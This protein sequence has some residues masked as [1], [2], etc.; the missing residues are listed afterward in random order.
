MAC[1]ESHKIRMH[2]GGLS[3]CQ[4]RFICQD[5]GEM[6][7]ALK[8]RDNAA[9]EHR[10]GKY[11]CRNCGKLL[12]DPGHFCF[13]KPHTDLPKIKRSF[14]YADFE[15]DISQ[16]EHRVI[17]A[18]A[19]DEKGKRKTFC[20]NTAGDDFSRWLFSKGHA[21]HIVIFHNLMAYDSAFTVQYLQKNH[22]YLEVIV[23]G[24][25]FLQIHVIFFNKAIL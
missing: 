9:N 16:A 22:T 15:S 1:F 17:G 5:C 10:C 23:K 11:E 18:V 2:L 6:V 3:E 8:K 20:G 14:L 13:I 7:N 25:K 12:A 24:L 19:V 4:I 21:D